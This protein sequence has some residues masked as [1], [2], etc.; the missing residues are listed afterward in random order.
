MH[1][2]KKRE[3]TQL[4]STDYSIPN[5]EP[6]F[7]DKLSDAIK[8]FK[9]KQDFYAKILFNIPQRPLT[10]KHDTIDL[11]KVQQFQVEHEEMVTEEEEIFNTI[12]KY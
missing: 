7:M 12:K 6:A 8:I 4:Y 10:S 1:E 3:H 2:L 11:T 9:R 5:R